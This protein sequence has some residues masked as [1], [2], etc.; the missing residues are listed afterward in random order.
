MSPY[1]GSQEDVGAQLEA[2]REAGI[3]DICL[4][5]ERQ[6]KLPRGL[7]L[8]IASRESRC[9]DVVGDGGHGR[10]LF[11]I[12]DRYHGEWLARHGAGAPGGT[13]PVGD[14]GEYAAGLLVTGLDYGRRNGV[15]ASD[16]LK[17]AASAYNAGAAGALRGYRRGD[18]DLETA[19]RDYG[20]DVL[21]RLGVVQRW[22]AG[23]AED[24]RALIQP[25]AR[26]PA[27]S[28][29]KRRLA[30]WF[31]AHPPA[32]R[33]SRGAVYGPAA[34]EAVKVFQRAN[35][36]L[37]DGIVGPQVFAA[38]AG[39]A[40][41][42]P[43]LPAQIAFPDD[44]YPKGSPWMGL[45]PWLVPQVKAICARFGL[46]V[47]AGWGGHPPHAPRSDHGWGGACDLAGLPEAMVACTLWA[48]RYRADP[49]RE[50]MVFRWVGGPA[51]D[52]SGVEPGHADHVHLSWY[53]MGP[54]TT[55]FSTPEFA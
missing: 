15:R 27:V 14:A 18:S 31:A 16:L 30:A 35:G 37:V 26:G 12:D 1:L 24:G 2:A 32:P 3:V 51:P 19:S 34:V 49:Y 4:E 41:Q 40:R 10:G 45:Q 13:P 21:E 11:Q 50:G 7:L 36:L 38:L 46:T 47:S 22:L 6:A 29:L 43:P 55:I 53:R 52:S 28:E 39:Q 42:V 9:R 33:F 48:D 44:L 54:A 5:A 20:A 25:G 17:F 23:G 8:A